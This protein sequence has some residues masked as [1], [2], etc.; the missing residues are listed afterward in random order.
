MCI[1]NFQEYLKTKTNGF[2][3]ITTEPFNHDE[4]ISDVIFGAKVYETKL[5]R[6]SKCHISIDKVIYEKIYEQIEINTD[7]IT[8]M[9]ILIRG[10]P[11][12]DTKHTDIALLKHYLSNDT[13]IPITDGITMTEDSPLLNLIT[14][15]KNLKKGWSCAIFAHPLVAPVCSLFVELC[16]KA[17]LPRNCVHLFIMQRQDLR[18]SHADQ[19]HAVGVVTEFADMES[20][21]DELTSLTSHYKYPWRLRRILVQENVYDRFKVLVKRKLQLLT[22][23]TTELDIAYLDLSSD[24]DHDYGTLFI[25]DDPSGDLDMKKSIVHVESYRTSK[26]AL[27][28]LRKYNCMFMSL[29]CSDMSTCNNIA[30]NSNVCFVVLNSGFDLEVYIKYYANNDTCFLGIVKEINTDKDAEIVKLISDFSKINV[31]G[32]VSFVNNI[33]KDTPHDVKE[34]LEPAEAYTDEVKINK[35]KIIM[36]IHK[37]NCVYYIFQFDSSVTVLCRLLLI[38]GAIL[39]GNGVVIADCSDN[40]IFKSLLNKKFPILF[41]KFNEKNFCDFQFERFIWSSF[42]ETFAN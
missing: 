16:F 36:R 38:M 14:V 37:R 42:G 7:L 4:Y 24:A 9:E 6:F 5:C 28:L 17:G 3:S 12:N 31:D 10:V 20:A 25:F 22:N 34:L 8:Q 35:N 15:I 41:R 30:Y 40:V 1:L 33:L 39:R 11:Q 2:H 27:L 13:Q 29:W 19:R 18:L 21:I 23:K 32:S 26:E